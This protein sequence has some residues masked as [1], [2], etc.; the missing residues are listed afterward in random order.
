MA[1][2]P[3]LRPPVSEQDNRGSVYCD[4]EP[5]GS[6]AQA[7]R[8]LHIYKSWSPD[9]YGGVE[10]IITTLGA[11]GRAYG[12]ESRVAYLGPGQRV[13]LVHHHGVA[14]YRFPL[15]LEVASTGMSLAF[16]LAYRRLT[17]WADILHFHFPWPY[18]DLIHCL[19]GV[20]KPFLITYHLDITK[21]RVLNILYAPLRS[22]FFKRAARV[23]ATS[24]NYMNSS[25]VLR[26][27]T[28]RTRV[29]PLGI[30]DEAQGAGI[31]LRQ[32]YWRHR[33][34]GAFVL[35]IGVLRYYKGLHVL[36]DA[37]PSI[38]H[39]IVIAGTGPCEQALK[40]QAK[41]LGLTNVSFLGEIDQLDK[42][43]LYRLST[44]FVFP[45]H[46]RSEAFGLSLVEAAMYGKPLVSCEIGTG[47]SFVNV[48][49]RT[50]LVVEPGNPQALST[51]VNRLL[52][53]R[54]ERERFG[55]HA[56]KRYQ[57]QFIAERM[58]ADYAREYRAV[59]MEKLTWKPS[60]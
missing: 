32:A 13:K 35:F 54:R 9:R 55:R 38:R 47:T 58:V 28:D 43:A 22:S 46:L 51:A 29:I 34:G 57:E 36:L 23:I 17:A 48:H 25:P 24:Q 42:D 6:I 31:P 52:V 26:R 40:R 56:R 2:S 30:E 39:H 20:G 3:L 53:D 60:H 37:A 50:G 18:G 33:L 11:G 41:I 1:G 12:I 16:L 4:F 15:G 8:V 59:L 49:E 27:F 14:G 21:Q 10:R 7:I 5:Q 45:S 44:V 19:S